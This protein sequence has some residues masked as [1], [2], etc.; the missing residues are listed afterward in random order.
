MRNKQ[1]AKVIAAH[2]NANLYF[3]YGL[4]SGQPPSRRRQKESHPE[5]RFL[6]RQQLSSDQ[7]QG[8]GL[9]INVR[10]T[11]RHSSEVERHSFTTPSRRLQNPLISPCRRCDLLDPFNSLSSPSTTG[12]SSHVAPPYY[13]DRSDTSQ[14]VGAPRWV[15]SVAGK[16]LIV[17]REDGRIIARAIRGIIDTCHRL[18]HRR[19]RAVA[20]TACIYTYIYIVAYLYGCGNRFLA[21]MGVRIA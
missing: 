16:Q 1:V 5:R 9:R 3:I 2:Q 4:E 7:H 18:H 10:L 8:I 21:C 6:S 17:N 19:L 20:A 12:I 14:S 11:P 13:Y 15:A